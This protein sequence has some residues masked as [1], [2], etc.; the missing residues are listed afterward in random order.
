MTL[1]DIKAANPGFFDPRMVAF[2]GDKRIWLEGG[3]LHVITSINS[4][5][6]YTIGQDLKLE[7]A[8]HED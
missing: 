2:H 3:E 7:Y 5:V 8:R 4:H 1:D 6:V